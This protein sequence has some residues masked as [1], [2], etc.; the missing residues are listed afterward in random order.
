[1]KQVGAFF[2][3]IITLLIAQGLAVSLGRLRFHGKKLWFILG[4]EL[5]LQ[6]MINA[7]IILI[8]G[9]QFYA[10]Y[11]VL[12]MDLP[13]ILLFFY[14]SKRRDFSTL[15]TILC[16]IFASFYISF[17]AIWIV[18]IFDGGYILYNFTRIILFVLTM[19]IVHYFIS[20]KYQL[21]QRE[22]DKG[23]GMFCIL[24]MICISAMYYQY[25][26]H[27]FDNNHIRPLLYSSSI[28]LIMMIIFFT[29][30]YV[31]HLLHERNLL[32]EQQ[33]ILALQSKVQWEM[34]EYQKEA[35]EKTNRK[36]HDFRFHTNNLIELLEEG[37]I[38]IALTYLKEQQ[39]LDIPENIEYCKHSSVNSILLHWAARIQEAGIL[40]D[41]KTEI[42]QSLTIDPM[43]LSSLFANAIENAYNGCQCLPENCAKYI[44]IGA[45][46]IEDR[47]EVMFTNSCQS[48]ICFHDNIP[49]SQ[50]EGGG[51]GI[52]SIQFIVKEYKGT[53]FFDA[54]DNEFTF[55]ADL[56]V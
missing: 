45:N 48:D 28:I 49:V 16:T 1:M 26:R 42:P 9:L 35:S 23:W 46:Y 18:N 36:W 19:F 30:F 4:L 52:R 54:R 47:L 31:F 40:L 24:P 8:F 2:V 33:R 29:L 6:V 3:P 25:Y 15:Y 38:N 27:G 7:P 37:E 22:M 17:T 20:E 34:F 32:R 41:I 43:E 53:V 5:M 10:K 56:Y 51:N 39:I 14:L 12:T 21:I 11:Y 55:R 13:A 44:T 50:N